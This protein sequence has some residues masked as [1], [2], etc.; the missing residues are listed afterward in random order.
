MS[1]YTKLEYGLT[2][3]NVLGWCYSEKSIL[4]ATSLTF[5]K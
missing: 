4:L 3:A 5:D 2:S 1:Y